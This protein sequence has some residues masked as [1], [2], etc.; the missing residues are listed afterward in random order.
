MLTSSPRITGGNSNTTASNNS[1][2]SS[3]TV[4][5]GNSGLTFDNIGASSQVVF[6][7]PTAS[8]GLRYT[9]IVENA[10][11]IQIKATGT[12][13]IRIGSSVS[14]AAGTATSMA[15]GSVL[16]IEAISSTEW[17]ATSQVGTWTTA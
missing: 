13:T 6:T 10:V 14:T 4:T 17:Y 2:S 8:R 7:L 3:Y 11:G 5:T 16:I 15:V 12:A 1:Q 9:F